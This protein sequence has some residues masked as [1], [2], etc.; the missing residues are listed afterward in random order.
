MVQSGERLVSTA[1]ERYLL[2]YM[3]GV[4]LIV[5]SL[6]IIIFIVFQKRKNKLLLDKIKQQ[7]A[8]EEELSNTQIEIQEQTLKNIGQ[9]LHDNI[10]QLLSVANMQLSIMSMQINQDIKDQFTE[11]KNVVKDSL[12]E[13]RALSK[14]LN[15]D[16]IVNRGFQQSVQNEVDRLN[17]LNLLKTELQVLGD[18]TL[19]PKNKD[20]IILFRI[21][22]EFISNTIKYAKAGTLTL[23]LNYNKDSLL[24]KAVDDGVGFDIKA[25]KLG[26]GLINMK[27]RANLINA[28]FQIDSEINK[29]TKLTVNYPYKNSSI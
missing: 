22:Q 14:S 25:A 16:V 9:E 4:L 24:I 15:S 23:V 5:C 27:N 7:Q 3:I 18:K 20:S 8:F 10:G 2:V 28:T 17:K 1:A 26:S 29:G 21:I 12:S 19:F 6:I 13:V 11:T